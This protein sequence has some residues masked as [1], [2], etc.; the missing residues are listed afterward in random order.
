MK[1]FSSPTILVVS[2]LLI[3]G[4]VL[5]FL[6]GPLYTSIRDTHEEIET[7]RLSIATLQEQQRNI[8]SVSKSFSSIQ[9][10]GDFTTSL[11]INEENSVDFFNSIDEIYSQSGAQESHLR[12][13]TPAR[14]PEYQ[15]LGIHFT[16]FGAYDT[17]RK[18][19]HQIQGSAYPIV[20]QS[21]SIARAPGSDSVSATIDGTIP[22]RQAL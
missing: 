1:H 4:A 15:V 21:I 8:T 14:S 9:A 12:I 10:Q 17:V 20:I 19:V 5:F 18:F 16:F 22:W 7:T 3:I 13:D 2:G 6:I 11:F